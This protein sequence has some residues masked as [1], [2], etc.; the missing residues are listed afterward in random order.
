MV[1]QG[2]A[3]VLMILFIAEII[4]WES[5]WLP[6][7][8]ASDTLMQWLIGN[9]TKAAFYPVGNLTFLIAFSKMTNRLRFTPDVVD[10]IPYIYH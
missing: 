2:K 7:I 8:V 9:I 3:K 10:Y 5:S 1:L 4:F 6:W